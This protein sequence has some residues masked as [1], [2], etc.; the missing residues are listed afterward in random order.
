MN[1][2]QRAL[3]SKILDKNWEVKEETVPIKK[4]DLC[5]ELN[6]LKNELKQSM[7]EAAYNEYMENGRKMFASIAQ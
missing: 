2:T 7:G 5:M 6:K 1:D 4:Y 3:F